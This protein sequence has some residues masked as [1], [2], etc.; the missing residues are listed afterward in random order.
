[1]EVIE[2]LIDI[3]VIL[4]EKG[5]YER[6][7][8]SGAKNKG[9]RRKVPTVD[10]KRKTRN[11]DGNNRETEKIVQPNGQ[12]KRSGKIINGNWTKRKTKKS[13]SKNMTKS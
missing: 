4:E 11:D 9:R 5:V 2:T 6:N 1:M 7:E 10:T 12:I 13:K 3:R 8:K